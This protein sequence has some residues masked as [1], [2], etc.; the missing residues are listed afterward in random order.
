M[1]L[2][3]L[4]GLVQSSVPP[5][6]KNEIAVASAGPLVNLMIAAAAGG[7]LYVSGISFDRL[8]LA[9][10]EPPMNPG[11]LTWLVVVKLTIWI[12]LWVFA[13]NML[14]ALPLDGGR[15][16]RGVLWKMIGRRRA[17][18][19]SDGLARISGAVLCLSPAGLRGAGVVWASFVEIPL[20]LLGVFLLFNPPPAALRRRENVLDDE[21]FSDAD[22]FRSE[23]EDSSHGHPSAPRQ[24]VEVR[25]AEKLRRQQEFEAEEDRRVDEILSRLGETG[26]EGLVP[27]D[28]ELLERVSERYRGERREGGRE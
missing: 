5:S 23:L 10:F 6:P 3:P 12:N 4:G 27:E 14:P 21:L 11:G 7:V 20:I 2:W 16:A 22:E 25:L 24:A 19:Y 15:A 17:Q 13:I 26:L 1:I 9:I 28:R 8:S 18:R